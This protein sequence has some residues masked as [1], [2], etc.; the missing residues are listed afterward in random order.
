M[1]RRR[2][3]TLS[4]ASL[5][6]SACRTQ[7]GFDAVFRE[8]PRPRPAPTT[9]PATLAPSPTP[10]PRAVTGAAE[11]VLVRAGA[12]P[13][14]VGVDIAA[15]KAAFTI[16]ATLPITDG[17]GW[18]GFAQGDGATT[19]TWYDAATG[20]A[21]RSFGV[22]GRFAGGAV[23]HNDRWLLLVQP[24]AADAAAPV[25]TLALCALAAG[26]VAQQAQLPGRYRADTVDDFGYG[27]F[28]IA[29]HPERKAD[30]YEVALFNTASKQ[31]QPIADKRSSATIMSGQRVRQAWSKTGEWL[32]SLY[33]DPDGE[34]AFIHALDVAQKF[35]VCIDLPGGSQPAAKLE[36]YALATAPARD[37]VYA[38][39]PALGVLASF[40]AGEFTAQTSSLAV[41]GTDAAPGGIVAVNNCLT[42]PDG[43]TLYA[44]SDRGILALPLDTATPRVQA[45]LLP[46]MPVCSLGMG[47]SGKLLYALVDTAPRQ[48]LALD[49][50][51][52]AILADLSGAVSR[53]LSI[54]QVV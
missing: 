40:T 16:P 25:S 15:G 33:L 17:H 3:L 10:V 53:P 44:G 13:R 36:Q 6:L 11:R 43:A 51:S 37:R 42:T 20:A 49:P 39:N 47:A 48:L 30:A 12:P 32:S 46:G 21:R 54:E 18:L 2:F 29:E 7:T 28:L 5:G 8:P 38:I 35:A 22:P 24:P 45:M 27:A 23:S 31:V 1:H 19:V 41:P 4:L 14:L 50:K 34:G 52:G 9:A 26:T